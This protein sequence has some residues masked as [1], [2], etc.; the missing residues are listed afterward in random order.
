[1]TLISGFTGV[2]LLTL[3]SLNPSVNPNALQTGQRI[4]L[5]R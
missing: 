2:P 1:M 3:E 5:Q 4:R